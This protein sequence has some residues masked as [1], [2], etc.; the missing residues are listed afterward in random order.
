LTDFEGDPVSV[1]VFT[2]NT[3]DSSTFIEQVQKVSEKFNVQNVI[4]VGDRGMIKKPQIDSL[5]ES[6]YYISAIT[7]P[8]NKKQKN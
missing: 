6:F 5:P 2:G 4:M 8:I 7:K 1:Q 3:P